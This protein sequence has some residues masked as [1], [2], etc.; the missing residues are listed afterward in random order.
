MTP[1]LAYLIFSS[2]AFTFHLL[3]RLDNCHF[4]GVKKLSQNQ[5]MLLFGYQAQQY[6]TQSYT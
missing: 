3:T 1:I 6:F 5:F 4:I 2:N